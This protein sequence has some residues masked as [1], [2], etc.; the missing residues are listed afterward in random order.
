MRTSLKYIK[1]IE[2]YL[3]GGLATGDALLF[4]ANM[5]LNSDLVTDI[6]H[7]QNTYTI[8]KQY[9]RRQLKEEI[10]AV[11]QKLAVVSQH[12]GFIQ[13]IANLFKSK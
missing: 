12:Q 4:Q 5:L 9:G 2:E 1:T 7:Q 13:H 10:I 3:N 8:I 11:Q 6:K